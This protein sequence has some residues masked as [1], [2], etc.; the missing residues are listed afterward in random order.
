MRPVSNTAPF[1]KMGIDESR[2]D[3]IWMNYYLSFPQTTVLEIDVL[4][5][6]EDAENCW[7]LVFELKNRDAK[8]P[9]T[10]KEAKD[11]LT[12]IKGVKQWL[13]ESK[14]TPIKFVCPVYLSAKGFTPSVET[15]LHEQGILTADW[16]SW[17]SG[18]L[19]D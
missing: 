17:E 7:A 6:G 14:E 5:E 16:E 18:S 11:F 1:S 12:K 13:T 3:R 8:N 9:P 10:M 19:Q 4:A 2:F 15:W